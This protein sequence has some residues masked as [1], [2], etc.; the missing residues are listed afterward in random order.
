VQI[1]RLKIQD[2]RGVADRIATFARHA[3]LVRA[4][5]IT[6][7]TVCEE[8]DLMLGPECVYWSPIV[9]E[10]HNGPYIADNVV[11]IASGPLTPSSCFRNPARPTIL[12]GERFVPYNQLDSTRGGASPTESLAR[13]HRVAR[14]NLQ[15]TVSRQAATGSR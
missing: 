3:L 15:S 5:N 10:V 9:D 12:Q 14:G 2:S 1:W 8:L 4:H 13:L 7:S 11:L 6:K